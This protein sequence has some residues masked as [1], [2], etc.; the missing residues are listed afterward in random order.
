MTF[1]ITAAE[2]GKARLEADQVL[3]PAQFH[4]IAAELR[5]TPIR[6]RKVGYVAARQARRGETIE[7]RWNGRE[8]TNT[9]K[10]GDWI[11]TNLSPEQVPL[12]DQDGSLNIYV[13]SAAGFADLYEPTDGRSEHGAIYRPKG[14]VEAL[15]LPGGFDILAP[16]GE[17]QQAPA[18]YLLFNG[19]D[20]YGNNAE[21]FEVTYAE[22]AGS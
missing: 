3:G 18:G 7:T 12:R 17:R 9:A 4:A 16:W 21:T 20:V 2:S 1:R 8:T 14:V 10:P 6:A 15:S 19:K 5:K 13:I 22:I 11:V